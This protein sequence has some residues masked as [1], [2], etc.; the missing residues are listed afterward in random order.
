LYSSSIEEVKGFCRFHPLG[1]C[2]S[3]Y[4][5]GAFFDRL[6]LA[7]QYSKISGYAG[8]NLVPGNAAEPRFMA[9]IALMNPES[10]ESYAIKGQFR[11]A[12]ELFFEGEVTMVDCPLMR[13]IKGQARENVISLHLTGSGTPTNILASASIDK[14][15]YQ[16]GGFDLE[17]RAK[18]ES[19]RS[20]VHAVTR[21]AVVEREHI[22]GRLCL[23]FLRYDECISVRSIWWRTR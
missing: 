2:R 19:C 22:V 5:S 9:D 20:S 3:G 12:S 14:F 11:N 15:V 7:D 21:L 23:A 13:F 1:C 16:L 18:T 6:S 4:P 8:I 17:A 10:K